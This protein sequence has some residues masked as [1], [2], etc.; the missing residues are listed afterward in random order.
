MLKDL[1]EKKTI[2]GVPK[3]EENLNPN[4]Q[5][6]Y[7]YGQN[8]LR[9]YDYKI[10]CNEKYLQRVDENYP[11]LAYASSVGEVGLIKESFYR[12]GNN[13]AFQGLFPKKKYSLRVM[14]YILASLKLHFKQFNY[15]TSMADVINL[16][17]SLPIKDGEIDY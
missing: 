14:L 4:E 8:I 13:G 11:I 15:D 9:Q 6:F 7:M 17:I 1:F 10:L 5:G 12:S 16:K 2:R 3:K